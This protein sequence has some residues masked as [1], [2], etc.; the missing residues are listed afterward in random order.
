MLSGGHLDLIIA[1][2]IDLIISIFDII[3]MTTAQ[4][5]ASY[6]VVHVYVL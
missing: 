5:L 6:S 3:I 1:N 2:I 4:D